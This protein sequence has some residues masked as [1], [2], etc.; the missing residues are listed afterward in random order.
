MELERKALYNLL[1]MNWLRD[2][3]I[4]I[5][6]W[7]VE[8]Y[9]SKSLNYLFQELSKLHINMDT[10]T[11]LAYAEN[12]DTPEELAECLFSEETPPQ[13]EDQAYLIIFELWRRL[14]PEK[15]SLSI[16]CDEL[17]HQIYLYDE[18]LSQDFEGLQDSLSNLSTI[19]E[20]NVDRGADPQ[21]IFQS[22]DSNCGND[23]ESFL[24]DFIAEQID[25]EL[26]DYASE[27]IELFSPF[28]A[29]QKWF[30]FLRARIMA[31]VDMMKA[32]TLV[33]ELIED[34]WED[35]NLELYLEILQ[36]LAHWGDHRFFL[37][38]A[39][40]AL[41]QITTEDEFQDL[42]LISSDYYQCLD[43]DREDES[44]RKILTKRSSKPLEMPID[45]S[46]QDLLEMKN[47]LNHSLG[48]EI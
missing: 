34:H 27:L 46:D 29:D 47:I 30:D 40:K 35:V 33:K 21:V 45:P 4:N 14:V 36:F 13:T 41:S 19:L 1:R 12:Y 2:P 16:F 3:S 7:Q 42:L 37:E 20:E 5:E 48:N 32:N 17:D 23:L 11:L 24:Y 9:R 38:L 28:M 26:F 44:I 43:H 8:D 15:P 10:P 25:D 31:P 6:P 39:A 22:V 18:G